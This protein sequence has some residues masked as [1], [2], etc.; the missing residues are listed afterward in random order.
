[1]RAVRRLLRARCS[2]KN[3]DRQSVYMKTWFAN[4]EKM[5]QMMI[6]RNIKFSGGAVES[7]SEFH[8][9]FDESESSLHIFA[10]HPV[11]KA[12][13]NKSH[14][15]VL[16][17]MYINKEAKTIHY[18]DPY[19][20]RPHD[21]IMKL[22][23]NRGYKLSYNTEISIPLWCNKLFMY[24][25]AW[26]DNFLKT[27]STDFRITEQQAFDAAI[28]YFPEH[29]DTGE[30]KLARLSYRVQYY[31]IVVVL[32]IIIAYVVHITVMKYGVG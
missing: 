20:F 10:S 9:L 13:T 21:E 26:T 6:Q 18:Y 27:G 25:V 2:L 14:K 1:M 23:H 19:A 7:S 30:Y 15:A 29:Y 17:S 22:A 24:P 28:E 8:E 3:I 12:A 16:V 4:L 32:S 31:A 11:G 5:K